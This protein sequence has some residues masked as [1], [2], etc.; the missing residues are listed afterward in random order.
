MM[1]EIGLCPN[2][3]YLIYS[4]DYYMN[5]DEERCYKCDQCKF[6]VK[7]SEIRSEKR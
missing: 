7:E 6:V 2:C 3:K 4:K 5:I 1:G